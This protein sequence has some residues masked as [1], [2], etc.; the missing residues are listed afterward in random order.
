MAIVSFTSLGHALA[1]ESNAA[2][3]SVPSRRR[4]E[5]LCVISKSYQLLLY[6]TATFRRDVEMKRSALQFIRKPFSCSKTF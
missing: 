6:R 1:T 4:V 2:I 5:R 3:E